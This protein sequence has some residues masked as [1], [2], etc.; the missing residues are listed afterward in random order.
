[1]KFAQFF[2][3]NG[4]LSI[5]KGGILKI[6]FRKILVFIRKQYIM[7]KFIITEE[8]KKHIRG[9]YESTVITTPE[10]NEWCKSNITDASKQICIIKTPNSGDK[11]MCQKMTGNLAREKGYVNPIKIDVTETN[12]CKAVWEKMVNESNSRLVMESEEMELIQ[13]ELE[14]NGVSV[15]VGEIVDPTEPLCTA[16]QTGNPEEDN[17]LSKVWE[18]AQSQSVESLQDMK[19]KIKD[20]ISKAKELLKGK[21]VDEQVAPLLVIG[22]VSITASLLIAVGA[23]LLFIIIVAIIIKR[24]RN[25]SPCKRRRKLVRRF[26]M[27]GNFM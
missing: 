14:N 26:G 12:Y 3:K 15:P 11:N 8:D 1:M 10:E 19:S 24:S 20:S 27:D 16:P 9:L 22:G 21:R 23:L 2:S 4:P 13:N 18:W 6:N 7:G 5:W 25:S 17:V